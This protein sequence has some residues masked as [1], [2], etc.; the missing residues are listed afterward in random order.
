MVQ[1]ET[2]EI[3]VAHGMLEGLL[4]LDDSMAATHSAAVICHPHPLGG[5]TLNN[6]VVATLAKALNGAGMPALRFNFRGVGRSTGSYDEGRG[7]ADDVR[8]AL[9]WLAERYPT[10][11]LLL[12]GFSFGTW[13]G[14]PVG[15][16]DARVTRLIG[17]GVPVSLLDVAALADC[18]KS[19]LIVQG[20]HDE[21]GSLDRLQDW[22]DQLTA[23]KDL[24]IVG[25]SGHF[26]DRHL[27][28]VQ[29]IVTAWARE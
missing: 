28:E 21:Y 3:P 5:G 27:D 29:A 12:A 9:A 18:P 11:S 15:C 10:R 2:V 8:A 14:L 22:Y 26:F 23:P 7:E 13:I 19:K 17:V 4:R 16:A 20:D 24:R 25:D 1:L 6:K